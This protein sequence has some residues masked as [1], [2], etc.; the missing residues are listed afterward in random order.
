MAG[1]QGS[2]DLHEGARI[3][4]GSVSLGVDRCLLPGVW[5]LSS[6]DWG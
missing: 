5:S 4:Y 2:H 3:H 1:A 6:S